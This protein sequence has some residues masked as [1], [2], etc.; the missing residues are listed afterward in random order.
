MPQRVQVNGA[1]LMRAREDK[2]AKYHELLSSAKCRLVVV[3]LETGGKWSSEAIE[4]V[5]SLAG[6]ESLLRRCVN[7]LSTVG[8]EGGS[9]CCKCLSRGPLRL[10]WS[11]PGQRLLTGKT[12][13]RPIWSSCFQLDLSG[14]R[15]SFS[16][17]LCQQRRF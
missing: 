5:T 8:E 9:G 10:R 16:S 12:G 6:S 13:S 11:L 2:E 14:C 17:V 15:D 4:F 7:P 3:A 1:V